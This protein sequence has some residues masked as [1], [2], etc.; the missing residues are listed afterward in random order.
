[1]LNTTP[2]YIFIGLL[3]M[4]IVITRILRRRRDME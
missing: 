1:M 2:L 3:V 4:A